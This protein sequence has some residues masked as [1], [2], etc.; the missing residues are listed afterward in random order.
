VRVKSVTDVD[1]EAQWVVLFEATD[2]SKRF[3]DIPDIVFQF[4]VPGARKTAA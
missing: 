2:A 1:S 4:R 3:N